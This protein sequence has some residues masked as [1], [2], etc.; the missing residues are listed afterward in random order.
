MTFVPTKR[1]PKAKRRHINV[2]VAE[3]EYQLI[4][5]AADVAGVSIK[6]FARQ[7]IFYAMANMEKKTPLALPGPADGAS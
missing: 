4:S 3:A 2:D 5:A 6:S 7:A 1:E